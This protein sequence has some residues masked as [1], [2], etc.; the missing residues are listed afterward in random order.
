MTGGPVAPATQHTRDRLAG[1]VADYNATFETGHSVKDGRGFYAY[2]KELGKR[3]KMRDRKG[4]VA[5]QGID[6]LLVVNMFLT[7]FDA[8]TVNTLYVDKRL[9]WHGLIQ[10]FSRTNRI[11]DARKSQGNVVCFRNLK[12]QVDEA[13]ALFSNAQARDVVLVAPYDEQVD[14]FN[15]AVV[16]LLEI[17]PKPDDV[18]RLASEDDILVFVRAFRDLMRIRNVVVTFAEFEPNDLT[19][20]EQ[21]FEDYKSKYLDIHDRACDATDDD[22]RS[23][24]VGEVDFELELIRR[25]NINVA[26][27]LALLAEANA[28]DASPADREARRSAVL[29]LLD[30]EPG[31]R[32]KRE[33]I[34]QFIA[35]YLPAT[36]DAATVTD[37]FGTYWA[38]RQAADVVA[39]SVEEGLKPERLEALLSAYRFS[40]TRPLR[41]DIISAA[42]KPPG[43]LDRRTL[44]DRVFRRMLDHLETFE[45]AIG[46][47]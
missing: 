24:I 42:L 45:D 12:P 7:G 19:M 11:L 39:I 46:E 8:K 40:G 35:S 31:L 30:S 21:R 22:A 43:I 13:I 1:Y 34:E 20:T 16:R 26:Y 6:V 3:M 25:D 15:E 29:N 17:V 33:L 10:A 47:I 2:Y 18:D 32:S 9:R 37:A 44:A 4:F 27:I 38:E 41:D 5:A 36:G 28:Q 14:R 23:S